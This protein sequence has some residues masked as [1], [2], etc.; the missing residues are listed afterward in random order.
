M[1]SDIQSVNV[2]EVLNKLSRNL[3][4]FNGPFIFFWSSCN[5][6][7]AIERFTIV[8]LKHIWSSNEKKRKR[9]KKRSKNKTVTNV[10]SIQVLY[11]VFCLRITKTYRTLS[12]SR[13]SLIHTVEQFI[14]SLFIF[15]PSVCLWGT[16]AS[17]VTF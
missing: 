3:M 13:C 14:F 12:V 1:K 6:F 11:Q 8:F 10:I 15:K 4:F 17:W 5:L 2:Q 7:E 9:K 16:V